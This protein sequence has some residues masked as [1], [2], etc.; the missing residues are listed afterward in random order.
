MADRTRHFDWEAT[1]LGPIQHWP[2]ELINTVNLL[3]ASR[4]PMF[5]WWGPE[6]IQFYNDA[7]RPSIRE[8]KH[9]MALGQRGEE[10]WREIWPIIGPEIDQVM[11]SGEAVWNVNRL[12]PI[13][14]NKRIEEVFWTYSYSPVRDGEGRVQGVLVVCSETTEQV[15]SER[16]LRSLLAIE[17]KTS[18]ETV[19]QLGDQLIQSLDRSRL[20]IPFAIL[21]CVENDEVRVVGETG[22]CGKAKDLA[23]ILP[24]REVAASGDPELVGHFSA[25]SGALVCEPWSEPIEQVYVQITG[26][27][28][29]TRYVLVLGASPRLSFDDNY[30]NFFKLVGN[31][32]C[33]IL[34]S[35]ARQEERSQAE[36]QR[37]NL[38]QTVD[39]QRELVANI[40]ESAP[41][42][43]AV[44]GEDLRIRWCNPH[45][46]S[47]LDVKESGDAL[48]GMELA[49]AIP[50]SE[51][52][53][54][55]LMRVRETHE[56]YA[57]EEYEHRGFARGVT[58]WRWSA[59]RLATADILIVASEV[60]DQVAARR[61]LEAFG[62]RLHLAQKA[63]RLGMY[64]WDLPA[65]MVEW[66]GE[67]F[68][69]TGLD[70]TAEDG[71]DSYVS[72]VHPKDR[73]RLRRELEAAES[74]AKVQIHD[75]RIISKSG[76][77]R[78]IELTGQMHQDS[79]GLPERII[80]SAADITERKQ[81]EKELEESK[82][83]AQQQWAELEAIY[84][85]A[86]IGLALFDPVE[87]RYLRLNSR[88]AEIVGL[89]AE[90]ILGKTLTEIAPIE[91][92]HEMFEQ[93]ARGN[94]VSNA[95]LEGEMPTSPG[96]H[97]YWTVNYY[98]VYDSDGTIQAISAASLEITAQ[99]RAELAL[100][101]S[102]KIA[103]V[104]R[105]ASSIS[106]EINNPLEAV[107]NLMYLLQSED[108]SPDGREYLAAAQREL[109]RVSQIATHTLRFHRQSTKATETGAADMIDPI[110]TLHQGRLNGLAIT[111]EKQY[112]TDTKIVCFDGE[113]RQVL[114]N[115]IG[116]SIDAMWRGGRLKLRSQMATEWKTGQQ[117]LCITIADT[118]DGMSDVTK[119]RLF[120]AFFTTKGIK[121][122]GLGLWI[123]SEIVRKH[124]GQLRFRSSRK[125]GCSGTV[126][127]LFLPV[128]PASE[129]KQEPVRTR[130]I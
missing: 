95:L 51:E 98:P 124:G 57:A 17:K 97:R 25:R 10:C 49:T 84:G 32:I 108:L 11:G 114:N 91:G 122:T 6:H 68:T 3:L 87:F 14:R 128:A 48:I 99:K 80:G 112:R 104:G 28:S 76:Q 35:E 62:E 118:G 30:A 90:E 126:F 83:D 96:E 45:F 113:I 107:T 130:S 125:E 19:E 70:D 79:S 115:L 53:S 15:L 82:K 47:F 81:A 71:W 85:T 119:R 110:L 26:R 8:D 121:G 92:L 88:Q 42:G 18:A 63:A 100:I 50:Q 116:N 129:E 56:P 1:C 43:I 66:S 69:A 5:L 111:V 93:V 89:P 23:E 16:R 27:I 2:D 109:A 36:A 86:P 22:V 75:H 31:R 60:T 61:K 52:V 67:F 101:Q 127:Q 102:E 46:V 38:H 74:G 29:D 40:V 13:Y 41:A 117:R 24:I 39:Q 12:V 65:G 103:A 64:C 106:H 120:E 34:E 54:R 44:I 4:Y 7:Y 37:R 123:S 73:E 33:Q 9:P 55:I 72:Q 94:P 59:Q 58:Y 78:W 20:D 77:E 105:L 21:Y